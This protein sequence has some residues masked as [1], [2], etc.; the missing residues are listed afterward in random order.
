MYQYLVTSG[1]SFSDSRPTTVTWP[2]HLAQQL[3]L[4]LYN[5]AQASVGNDWIRR[6]AIYQCTQLLQGGRAPDS[7]L[8]MV[9]WSGVD[10]LSIWV[11]QE[12][13]PRFNQLYLEHQNPL[14]YTVSPPNTVL[15]HS[16]AQRGW[17]VGSPACSF[18]GTRSQ[19]FKSLA[20]A[21]YW[22]DESL[23]MHT[24]EQWQ[25][26]SAWCRSEGIALGQT[27]WQNVSLWPN[28]QPWADQWPSCRDLLAAIRPQE[29]CWWQGDQGQLEFTRDQGLAFEEDG[30]HPGTDANRLWT[31]QV[32]VPWL[33]DR[34]GAEQ[35]AKRS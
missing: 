12:Q 29:W 14:D 31:Q 8:C 5:R 21:Q 18:L 10:R 28:A 15:G 24:L 2:R 34:F 30:L 16:N 27:L 7:I 23:V 22:P 1:C 26:L 9:M 17:L 3:G 6:S 13:T 4:D 11:N 33:E 20:I 35:F 25:M 32:L 19:H